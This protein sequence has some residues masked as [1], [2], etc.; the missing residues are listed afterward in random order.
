MVLAR[1]IMN[2]STDR[3]EY[4]DLQRPQDEYQT[5]SYDKFRR[6]WWSCAYHQRNSELRQKATG[7][8]R[9]PHIY[10][11]G[12]YWRATACRDEPS[13]IV[14]FF[15]IRKHSQKIIRDPPQNLQYFKITAAE[16]SGTD[17]LTFARYE[18]LAAVSWTMLM[19]R[20][21]QIKRSIVPAVTNNRK[22]LTHKYHNSWNSNKL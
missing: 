17:R 5:I 1:S 12:P 21:C 13:I 18:W 14:Y 16:R 22:F 10:Y 8:H 9:W 20:A 6:K 2:A 7:I 15:C 4:C 11:S 19:V 3:Q